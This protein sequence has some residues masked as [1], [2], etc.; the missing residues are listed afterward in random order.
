METGMGIRRSSRC[1]CMGSRCSRLEAHTSLSN[2]PTASEPA[3]TVAWASVLVSSGLVAAASGSDLA[4][5]QVLAWDRGPAMGSSRKQYQQRTAHFRRCSS[6]SLVWTP[7]NQ[8]RS[9][10]SKCCNRNR[11]RCPRGM[12]HRNACRRNSRY[13]RLRN[14]RPSANTSHM[15]CPTHHLEVCTRSW[16]H[17]C[18]WS[19]SR[20]N[21]LDFQSQAH[22]SDHPS[23]LHC[24]MNQ[25]G[26]SCLETYQLSLSQHNRSSILRPAA[27]QTNHCYAVT[28]KPTSP[29]HGASPWMC[30]NTP[31]RRRHR[32]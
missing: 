14:L 2:F 18:L 31:R 32:L 29:P 17:T 1:S 16:T 6:T 27:P 21:C 23:H 22:C 20:G 24:S 5:A 19:C 11:A 12:W 9:W 10:R 13:K 7:L 4:L 8:A 28:S 26:S 30:P 15:A 25:E 3:G